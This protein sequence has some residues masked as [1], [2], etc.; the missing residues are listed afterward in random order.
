MKKLIGLFAAL[1]LMLGAAPAFANHIQPVAPEEITNTDV[2]NH[3]DAG[4]TAL[5]NDHLGE[6]AKQ[7]QMAEEA[8]PTLPEVHINL[9]MTLAAEGKKE[10]ANRHFNEATNLLAKAGSS[11][12]AQSQG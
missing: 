8:D 3:F 12:G 10:A 2:K 5:M 11:N 9:A 7:F 4:V 1:L 6:A